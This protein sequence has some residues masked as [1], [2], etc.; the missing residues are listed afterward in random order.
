MIVVLASPYDSP[1]TLFVPS[2]G[3]DATRDLW[4][5]SQDEICACIVRTHLLPLATQSRYGKDSSTVPCGTFLMYGAGTVD[6]SIEAGG[7]G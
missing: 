3:D 5:N 6:L 4:R 1:I 7:S 2:A